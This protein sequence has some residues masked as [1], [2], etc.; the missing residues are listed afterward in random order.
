MLWYRFCRIVAASILQLF[1]RPIRINPDR[2]PLT[3]PVLLISNHQSHFDPPA[4]ACCLRKRAC[5]FLAR[6]SLFHNP[7]FGWLIRSLNS[8]PIKRDASD[9]AAMKA[10]L[11]ALARGN[12]ILVFPE[13][14][15]SETGEIQPFKRGVALLIKRSNAPVVPVAI[16]GSRDAWPKGRPFPRLLGARIAIAFGQPIDPDQLM[17]VGADQAIETIRQHILD[18]HEQTRQALEKS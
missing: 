2:V 8:I 18:L 15:R 4:I 1:Y 14:T 10:A 12:P 3:G 17:T 11:E 5:A 7:L 6:E 16:H 13:G 9:T